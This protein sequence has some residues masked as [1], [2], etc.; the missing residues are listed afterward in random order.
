MTKI[1]INDLHRQITELGPALRQALERTLTS[2]WYVLGQECA[3]FEQEFA[4]YCE[5]GH[6]VTLA[7]GTDALELSLRALGIGA[8]MRV[9]TVANA[10][11][12]SAAAI[13]IVG[14]TPV[15]VDV[16]AESHLMDL[17]CLAT[18]LQHDRIDAVIVTHLYGLMHDVREVR[19]LTAP[20]A[21]PII[22]DCAQAHGAR[23]DGRR[24]GSMGDIA[25]F[26][27][28]PTKNLGALGD[29]GG[30]VTNDPQLADRLRQ[31]R[32]YGWDR[33]YSVARQGGRNSRLDEIQAA[34]LRVKL[35]YL[36][37]WNARR[38]AIA[39][40]YAAGISNPRV[41]C[42]QVRGEEY[43]AHLFV[44]TCG[45]PAGLRSH[46]AA[47]DIVTDIHY[48]IPDHLQPAVA[49]GSAI[50]LPVTERLAK[51]ILTLPCFVELGDNEVDQVIAAVN[52]WIA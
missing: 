32:Q 24:A 16:D 21:I 37:A 6:C 14:A 3:G 25:A 50:S 52:A 15:Y 48:P 39:D 45:D 30:A 11:F 35:P 8:G 1:A 33:K 31:L 28:Y 12:Y 42:P 27:F 47:H 10:G 18:L 13:G 46:L 36:D 38:R 34:V 20:L 41:A 51:R 19:E 44:V 7:N 29:G 43:V 4:G 17:S 9:A 26:S 2:G 23:R 5:A 22:E 40:R 49:A